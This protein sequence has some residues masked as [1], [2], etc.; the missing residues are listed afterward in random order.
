MTDQFDGGVPDWLD[1]EDSGGGDGDLPDWLDGDAP[2]SGAEE[3][4]GEDLPDWLNMPTADYE[5]AVVESTA[6]LG[7]ADDSD[8]DGVP[9]WVSDAPA[10]SGDQAEDQPEEQ[11]YADWA[12]EH[13]PE[14]EIDAPAW[15][16]DDV[17][18]F[19]EAAA[20]DAGLT[21]EEWERQQEEQE[22]EATREPDIELP[23]I[24]LE[25]P[26]LMG[27]FEE[28]RPPTGDLADDYMP[29]WFMGVEE[30][31]DAD[32]PDWLKGSDLGTGQFSSGS[33]PPAQAAAPPP[34]SPLDSPSDLMPDF[35]SI[36][37]QSTDAPELPDFD[38][39]LGG[40]SPPEPEPEPQSEQGKPS[41]QRLGS[42]PQEVEKSDSAPLDLSAIMDDEP[43]QPIPEEQEKPQIRRL[44]D[45]APTGDSGPI[46]IDDIL[47]D[48]DA[49]AP[50]ELPEAGSPQD[51][52]AALFGEDEVEE[53]EG[54]ALD[55]SAPLGLD[56]P[57]FEADE[58]ELE[59]ETEAETQFW[60]ASPEL[61]EAASPQDE[62]AAF[63]GEDDAPAPLDLPEVDI[64]SPES[65]VDDLLGD[66]SAPLGEPEELE[67]E[68]ELET[69]SAQDDFAVFFGEDDAPPMD[70]PE[71]GIGSSAS[72]VDDLLGDLSAPLDESELETESELEL[73]KGSIQDDFAVFFGED[74]LPEAAFSDDEDLSE[75]ALFGEDDLSEA[76]LFDEDAD[77]EDEDVEPE[78]LQGYDADAEH[79]AMAEGQAD[80]PDYVEPAMPETS[81]LPDWF[82]D[83]DFDAAHVGTD[84]VFAEEH[85]EE[86]AEEDFDL[87]SLFGS[88]PSDSARADTAR[89]DTS[90]LMS[91]DGLDDLVSDED[92]G[93]DED[94]FA[95]FTS[96]PPEE[97]PPTEFLDED[98]ASELE[99]ADLEGSG[100]VPDWVQQ[101][102]ASS[103]DVTLST[104]GVEEHFEQVPPVVLPN[105][106]RAL[107]GE[108]TDYVVNAP[109]QRTPIEKGPL[110]GV[111]DALGIDS[112]LSEPGQLNLAKAYDLSDS[113]QMRLNALEGVLEAVDAETAAERIEI[114]Y[115]LGGEEHEVEGEPAGAPEPSRQRR[116]AKRRPD[117]LLVMLA[118]LVFALAPFASE[119]LH[120]AEDPPTELDEDAMPLA[121]AID[122]LGDADEDERKPVL[123]AIE[124]GP[125]AARE[126]D[127]LLEAVLWDIFVQGGRP[128]VTST[129]PLGLLHANYILEAMA[130]DEALIAAAPAVESDFPVLPDEAP[131][132][133]DQFT[134]NAVLNQYDPPPAPSNINYIVLRYL[135]GGAVGVRSLVTSETATGT[136]FTRDAFGEDTNLEIDELDS[137]DFAFIVVAGERYDDARIWAEQTS[138]LE[139]DKFALVSA[140]AE[141]VTRPYLVAGEY[142][143]MLSG[144]RGALMYDAARNAETRPPYEPSES[145]DIPDPTLSRWHS[146]TLG[147]LVAV[148][149]IA[150]GAL[151]NIV[152]S[153]RRREQH[154]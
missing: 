129:N 89:P 43:Q 96:A 60:D 64:E 11:T 132:G 152:R 42:A 145:L 3:E 90:S 111:D 82:G 142:D 6:E 84:D 57:E 128:V 136:I 103:D 62:F 115:D 39:F 124:Y 144:I 59:P 131:E 58:P 130:S 85:E 102:G 73:E 12:R 78:W 109:A 28:A 116:R 101:M 18:D 76:A 10:E 92:L 65:E 113:Q 110:A 19:A 149:V 75:A 15:I 53:F 35:D 26:D 14:E 1:D 83:V 45:T 117:R 133:V 69:G 123:V 71:V 37:G 27:G 9:D 41:I 107:R 72:G 135:P 40:E 5:A 13:M 38:A 106:L 150:A 95:Q 97:A 98:A 140:A 49:S 87:D 25:M 119:E 100:I 63:F 154:S 22:F 118:L 31:D 141:P 126:M 61:P 114:R 127:P 33:A 34:S 7:V 81:T 16:S 70:L 139:V 125:G 94:V 143:G 52:F 48:D 99:P 80:A 77:A 148:V 93:F 112:S 79:A 47:L 36:M 88:S 23:D 51:E 108:I 146:A 66:L 105:E 2:A 55:L 120:I 50:P 91:M 8:D 137:E 4:S 44:G 122:E 21:Y 147:I 67:T 24:D 32:A 74:D 153:I 104:G 29:E 68:T 151:F 20:A 56:M 134:W 17:S 138:A 30:L 54:D 86:E 121:A 46:S